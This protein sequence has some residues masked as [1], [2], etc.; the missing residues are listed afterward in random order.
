MRKK[1]DEEFR[2]WWGRIG[3]RIEEVG[4]EEMW[5][6]FIGAGEKAWEQTI[7]MRRK[8]GKNKEKREP[9]RTWYETGRDEEVDRWKREDR[10]VRRQIWKERDSTRRQTLLEIHRGLKRNIRNK[11]RWMKKK[12]IGEMRDKIENWRKTDQR[13]LWTELK[14]MA[15][16]DKERTGL[17]KKMIDSEETR[18]TEDRERMEVW[19]EAWSTLGEEIWRMRNS[20]RH[21]PND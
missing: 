1:T 2:G 6:E 4:M 20:T 7:G 11:V 14:K 10:R 21:L 12:K 18:V 17:P 13:T 8:E 15:K 5:E 16:W 9:E 19:R 3:S